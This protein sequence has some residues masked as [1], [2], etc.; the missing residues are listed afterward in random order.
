[1]KTLHEDTRV[2]R[3]VL[4]LFLR[5]IPLL[6]IEVGSG[7]KKMKRDVDPCLTSC[8]ADEPQGCVGVCGSQKVG[9]TRGRSLGKGGG[10][11]IYY[12]TYLCR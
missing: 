11:D 6:G 4:S 10:K 8:K 5:S 1:M 7:N 9:E 2:T 12:T 3:Q